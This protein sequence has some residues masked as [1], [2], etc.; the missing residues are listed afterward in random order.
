[1]QGLPVHLA[2][3]S[4]PSQLSGG[5][6]ALGHGG[7][8]MSGHT[9]QGLPL[10]GGGGA[11]APYPGSALP[12]DGSHFS[13]RGGAGQQGEML[14]PPLPIPLLLPV[15]MSSVVPVMLPAPPLPTGTEEWTSSA[16]A[17][18]APTKAWL[19]ALQSQGPRAEEGAAVRHVDS[20]PYAAIMSR[21]AGPE[22]QPAPTQPVA[23][24]LPKPVQPSADN[25]PSQHAAPSQQASQPAAL[26]EAALT[27]HQFQTGGV[28]EHGSRSTGKV[29]GTLPVT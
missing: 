17:L 25:A 8:P 6:A 29:R 12:L 24:E 3:P 19:Q 10:G 20:G 21:Q 22:A 14:H 5:F 7:T 23:H 26:T 13:G 18:P 27:A 16:P 1:M 4:L 11:G 15:P 2:L 9:V 28:F